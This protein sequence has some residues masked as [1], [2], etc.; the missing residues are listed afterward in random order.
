[1]P[2]KPFNCAHR[3]AMHHEPENT[4][5][6]F[7]RAA[8]MGAQWIETD[9][10]LTKDGDVIISH[11]P[12][13]DT[14]P[15]KANISTVTLEELRE[16]RFKGEPVPTLE[17][18]IIFSIESNVLLNIE[19]K[20][21]AATPGTVK[22]I[23]E[24]SLAGKCMISSFKLPALKEVKSLEPG[25]QTGYIAVPA[26]RSVYL[27]RAK[28]AGC[29]AV[30]PF[31]KLVTRKFVEAA[32]AQGLDVNVWTVNDEEGMRRMTD[33]GVDMIITNR[34]DTLSELKKKT[35]G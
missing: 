26:I 2:E 19:I 22:Q 29:D 8:D 3:G 25:I 10:R 28:S 24:H 20:D 35:G 4:M 1:M 23:R 6:A 16:L 12:V 21:P 14:G 5:R 18:L 31:Y 27:R 13:I 11:D 34:P 30:H 17:E 32:H 15:R 33:I 7:R 9:V